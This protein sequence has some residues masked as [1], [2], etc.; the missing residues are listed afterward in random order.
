MIPGYP[1]L[2]L[3]PQAS[4]LLS[5]LG[6]RVTSYYPGPPASDQPLDLSIL[7]MQAYASLYG[8]YHGGSVPFTGHPMPGPSSTVAIYGG[9]GST[10]AGHSG[11]TT[12]PRLTHG[13]QLAP[14]G[15]GSQA[16]PVSYVTHTP[17]A[18]PSG[19]HQ[20]PAQASPRASTSA[21]PTPANRS[22]TTPPQQGTPSPPIA[23]PII[24]EDDP[25]LGGVF[26]GYPATT[27][28]DSPTD[29]SS[30]TGE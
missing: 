10:P 15:H 29:V 2:T 30:N 19:T 21:R 14:S 3:T 16:P 27:M 7:G 1:N 26:M 12:D 20:A 18:G 28:A 11:S 22:L 24:P 8:Q 13:P 17:T 25:G 6:Q 5:A 4:N 23:E 9:H